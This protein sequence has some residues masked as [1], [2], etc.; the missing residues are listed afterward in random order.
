MLSVRGVDSA[1]MCT[2]RI[3]SWNGKQD[4]KE[5]TDDGGLKYECY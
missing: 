2:M 3:P 5:K 4:M 1:K